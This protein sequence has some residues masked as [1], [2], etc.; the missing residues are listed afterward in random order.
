[1][2]FY[3]VVYMKFIYTVWGPE[4]KQSKLGVCEGRFCLATM[5]RGVLTGHRSGRFS[6]V[7]GSIRRH[8]GVAVR[9]RAARLSQ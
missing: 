5:G 8:R 2:F 1:M 9:P 7:S 6:E 4:K 3:D